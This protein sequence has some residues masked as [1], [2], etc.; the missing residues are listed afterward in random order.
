MSGDDQKWNKNLFKNVNI[1][2]GG[3]LQLNMN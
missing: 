3:G 2:Y 1:R